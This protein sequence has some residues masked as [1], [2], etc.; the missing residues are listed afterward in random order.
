MSER[1][2]AFVDRADTC[3]HRTEQDGAGRGRVFLLYYFKCLNYKHICSTALHST[4]THKGEN[5]LLLL[6]PLIRC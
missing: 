5:E 6:L 4:L 2:S 1:L 3:A